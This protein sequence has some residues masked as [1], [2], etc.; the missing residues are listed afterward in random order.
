MTMSF[1]GPRIALPGNGNS[2]HWPSPTGSRKSSPLTLP[3][4][5]LTKEMMILNG[6]FSG[7][8]PAKQSWLRENSIPAQ[9]RTGNFPCR[10]FGPR[11]ACLAKVRMKFQCMQTSLV[12]FFCRGVVFPHPLLDP[13]SLERDLLRCGF[14]VMSS[15]IEPFCVDEIIN[16]LNCRFDTPALGQTLAHFSNTER[17]IDIGI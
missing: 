5:I 14:E 12:G 4:T 9:F 16:P 6:W 1:R 2:L 10:G 13:G 8:S 17:P 7:L 3:G 11:K 15:E